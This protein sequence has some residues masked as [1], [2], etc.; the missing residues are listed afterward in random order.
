MKQ[1]ED[2]KSRLA[3]LKVREDRREQEESFLKMSL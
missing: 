3:E 2:F 1:N